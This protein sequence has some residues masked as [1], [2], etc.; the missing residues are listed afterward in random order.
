MDLEVLKQYGGPILSALFQAAQVLKT[1]CDALRE[2][3]QN[4]V[5]LAE[6]CSTLT[7]MLSEKIVLTP[8]LEKPLLDLKDKIIAARK[9]LESYLP[10]P[11]QNVFGKVKAKV[12]K[13]VFSTI[14]RTTL[15]NI[16]NDLNRLQ[17]PLILALNLQS[18]K[19]NV[20]MLAMLL[21]IRTKLNE[22]HKVTK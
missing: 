2:I 1:V 14:D 17:H 15:A 6:L 16:V 9:W 4:I 11:T 10:P 12:S 20:E 3:D 18:N 5:V 8:A 19:A 22:R 21:D 13:V 7:S